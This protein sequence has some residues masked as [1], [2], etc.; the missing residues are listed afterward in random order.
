MR[1]S[2]VEPDGPTGDVRAPAADTAPLAQ[3]NPT[4]AAENADVRTVLN[5]VMARS[6]S[7]PREIK[8]VL[9]VVR[10]V[11]HLRVARI[12]TGKKVPPLRAYATWIVLGLRWPELVRWLEWGF[13]DLRTPTET[14]IKNRLANRLHVFEQL[15][16][17]HPFDGW[18]QELRKQLNKPDEVLWTQ[19]TT[20]YQFLRE[21]AELEPASRLS[22][23]AEIG[24]F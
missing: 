15:A 21:E 12:V 7:S 23:A 22:I 9:N 19:D 17:A 10:F 3:V 13:G 20:L 14:D 11:L 4:V 1:P 2:Q 8:R 16:A 6:Q 18:G 5:A 24:L